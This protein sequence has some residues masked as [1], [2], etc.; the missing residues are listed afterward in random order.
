MQ[1]THNELYINFDDDGEWSMP[2]TFRGVDYILT[3]PTGMSVAVDKTLT[4]EEGALG[5]DDEGKVQFKKLN[6]KEAQLIELE[7]IGRCVFVTETGEPV[8]MEKFMRWPDRIH[9]RLKKAMNKGTGLGLP[10]PNLEEA[11]KNALSD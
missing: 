10:Q 3:E 7:I 5:L 9:K 8:E 6:I 2:F 4:L 1:A 11:A